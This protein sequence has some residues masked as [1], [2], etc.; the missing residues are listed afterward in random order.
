MLADLAQNL[1]D[2]NKVYPSSLK[3]MT[4]ESL[5]LLQHGGLPNKQFSFI[6]PSIYPSI[7]G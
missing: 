6:R 3:Q 5:P 1:A 4:H 2:I 7:H